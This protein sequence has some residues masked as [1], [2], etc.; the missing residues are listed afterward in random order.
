MS[1][2]YRT[3]LVVHYRG[4]LARAAAIGPV[5]YC[6]NGTAHRQGED[7]DQSGFRYRGI[8]CPRCLRYICVTKIFR[9]LTLQF[10]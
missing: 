10:E 5:P 4:D 7:T 8:P 6:S 9:L 3:C 2:G 1:A